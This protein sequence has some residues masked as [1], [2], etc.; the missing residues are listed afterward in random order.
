MAA[1]AAHHSPSPMIA[2]V[3]TAVPMITPTPV[4]RADFSDPASDL[5]ARAWVTGSIIVVMTQAPWMWA[6]AR[7]RGFSAS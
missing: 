5:P 1:E 7:A 6:R 3:G 2:A 4:Q